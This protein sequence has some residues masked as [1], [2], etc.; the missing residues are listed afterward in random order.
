MRTAAIVVGA[1]LALIG[2][3]WILQGVGVL[4]GSFMTGQPEWAVYGALA[5]AAGATLIVL[6]RRRRPTP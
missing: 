6:A 3:V 5:V 1:L 2:T 4:P